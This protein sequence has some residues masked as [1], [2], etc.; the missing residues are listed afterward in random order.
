MYQLLHEKFIKNISI[1]DE[2]F[3]FCKTI[4]IPK[5][6]R[7]KQFLLQEG[8]V[9]KYTAFVNKGITRT[10]TIDDKGIEHILQFAMEGWW[11]GDIYSFLT[12]EPS[13]YNMEAL[14]DCEL[15]LINKPS[16]DLLLEKI[17]AL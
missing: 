17:P 4:F 13:L 14:E 12:D 7:K 11:M 10:Y 15:L 5:K 9:A 1:S 8:D 2:D 3:E 6:L 16:W